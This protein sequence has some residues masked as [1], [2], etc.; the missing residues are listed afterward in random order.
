MGFL[1]PVQIFQ[2][3]FENTVCK[4]KQKSE[5]SSTKSVSPQSKQ[6]A[7]IPRSLLTHLHQK[8]KMKFKIIFTKNIHKIMILSKTNTTKKQHPLQFVGAIR[9]YYAPQSVIYF[10]D[11]SCKALMHFFLLV[12][13]LSKIPFLFRHAP[14]TQLCYLWS[15]LSVFIEQSSLFQTYYA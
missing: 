12:N 11:G 6:L 1:H 13:T 10:L 2:C 5:R 8:D 4:D 15:I 3:F 9:N 14:M 7:N